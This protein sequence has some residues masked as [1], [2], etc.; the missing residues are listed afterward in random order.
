V[1]HDVD[2]ISSASAK[3]PWAFGGDARVSFEDRDLAERRWRSSMRL[4]RKLFSAGFRPCG[5]SSIYAA[6]SP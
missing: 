4:R 5:S 1:V 6:S 2:G 3:R